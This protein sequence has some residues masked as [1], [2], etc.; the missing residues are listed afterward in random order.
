MSVSVICFLRDQS[1]AQRLVLKK[2]L[3]S[4]TLVKS[5]PLPGCLFLICVMKELVSVELKQW[6]KGTGPGL[7]AGGSYTAQGE[8]MPVGI[9]K[10]ICTEIP[11][12]YP[13]R[14]CPKQFLIEAAD[15][16]GNGESA[17]A[18]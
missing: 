8:A 16:Y 9:C 18:V 5:L 12:G 11:R 13:K 17:L 14:G 4:L 2:G 15:W 7:G 6:P 1:L 10:R 3:D